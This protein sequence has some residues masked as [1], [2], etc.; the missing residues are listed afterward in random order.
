MP[1]RNC[2]ENISELHPEM[3]DAINSYLDKHLKNG[4]PERQAELKAVEDYAKKINDDVNGLRKKVKLAPNQYIPHN[5]SE[6]IKEIEQR[7]AEQENKMNQSDV[8]GK[9]PPN[10][11]DSA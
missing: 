6:K 8:S 5:P 4:L 2:L 1:L 7:Y 3:R 9:V 11:N 10:E